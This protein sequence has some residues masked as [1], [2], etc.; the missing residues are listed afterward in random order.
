MKRFFLCTI[1]IGMFCTFPTSVLN[2]QITQRQRVNV[3][4]YIKR[5]SPIAIEEMHRT[6]VPASIKLAQ[7]ISESGAGSSRLAVE[8]NNHFGIKCKKEWTGPTISHTD[9]LPNECFRKYA[10]PEESYRDHSDFLRTR[11]HYAF[12]F[13]L[14]PLDYK[15]WAYG[16][17]KAGYATAPQYPQALLQVIELYE[18]YQY[19]RMGQ[20]TTAEPT[21]SANERK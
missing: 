17:K 3:Q 19:D 12:L 14:D 10:S 15:G 16:L 2:A 20:Q 9:D 8:G 6:G 5:F 4:E 7:G 11:S 21:R 1:L 18:L 13:Q